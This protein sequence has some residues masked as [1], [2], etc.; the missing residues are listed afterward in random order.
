MKNCKAYCLS[1]RETQHFTA[2]FSV[3]ECPQN[4][5]HEAF[6]A[7]V[8]GIRLLA[9]LENRVNYEKNNPSKVKWVIC[10]R[11]KFEVHVVNKVKVS[12][13]QGT[14]SFVKSLRTKLNSKN[15]SGKVLEK[16]LPKETPLGAFWMIYRTIN[17]RTT[18]FAYCE[19][20]C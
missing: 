8:V 10:L 16:E 13:K 9:Y 1:Q 18:V 7:A 6:I 14:K 2:S 19:N 11:L 3:L 15:L 5:L 4:R 12:R 17:F 20:V